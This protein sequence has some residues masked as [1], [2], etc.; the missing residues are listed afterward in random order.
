M[1]VTLQK[2]L[3]GARLKMVCIP[4]L[5]ML[6][7]PGTVHSTESNLRNNNYKIRPIPK[8]INVTGTVKDNKGEPLPGVVVKI[9]GTSTATSTDVN[10]VFRLNL[11]IGTETLVVS[12]LGFET[13]E[14]LAS[15]KT[16]IDIVLVGSTSTLEEVVVVGYG[17]QKKATVTGSIVTINPVEVQ[18]IP[19]ANLSTSL[20]GRLAGVNIGQSSGRP[21]ASTSLS[22]RTRSSYNQEE[23]LYV[24][25]GFIR[26]PGEG[27]AAFDLLDPTEV[28]SISIL[29]DASAA[30]YGARGAGGVVLVKTKSGKEGKAKINYSGSFG[31]NDSRQT[32]DMM[33]AF[34]HAS[35][36]NNALR[37]TNPSNF[38]QQANWFTPDELEAFRSLNYNWLDDVWKNSYTNRHTLNVSGGT[39]TVRYFG[40][41]AFYD[42]VGNLPN[43][44]YNKYTL[45]MG[46]DAD[47]TKDLTASIKLNY[48]NDVD[49]RPFN[50]EDGGNDAMDG[51]FESL[52]QTPRWIPPYLNGLP[53][54]YGGSYQHAIEI[55]N[56]G[57]YNNA[58]AS[59]N[60]MNASLE[61]RV[62]MVKGLTLR[63]GYNQSRGNG[64]GKSYRLPY[65]MYDFIMSGGNN[66]LFTDVQ[67]QTAPALVNNDNRIS[68]SGDKNKSYQ[69]NLSANYSKTF[70]KHSLSALLVYEQA[71]AESSSF[72]ITREG[73]LIKDLEQL[74]AF[75][76][77]RTSGN[78][79]GGVNGRL[80]YAGRINYDYAG[81]Y[82]LEGSFRY[83]GSTK[84]P[85]D[86]RWGFFPALSA[87]WRISEE[88][89][90]K[91]NVTFI[92]N[93]KLR[94]SAGLVGNDSF[95]GS[96]GQWLRTYS[97]TTG[98]Y[99]G[100]SGLTVAIQNRNQGIAS[101][102]VTWEKVATYNGGIDVNFVNNISFTADGFYRDSWDILS[103]PTSAL[104][105]T[106]G[107]GSSIPAIN[108]GTM[109]SWGFDGSVNYD[110]KIKED[111][112]YN[113]GV[114]FSWARSKVLKKFQNAANVGTWKD[115]I[116]KMP[117]W[118]TGYI[119]KGIIRTQEELDALLAQY[120]NYTIFGQAPQLGML[121]Y[122]DMG[123]PGNSDEKDGIITRDDERIIAPAVAALGFGINLGASYK[124][125]RVNTNIGLT[126]FGT[127]VFFDEEAMRAPTAA[128]NGPAFW[129]DHWTPENP[130]AAYPRPANNGQ[131]G[132]K[133]STFY[134]RD[135][136]TMNVNNLSA[137]YDLPASIAKRW[138]VPQFRVFFAGTNLWRIINPLDY[139][140]VSLARFNSYPMI[141]SYNFGLN[142]TI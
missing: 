128:L 76:A 8:W 130:D 110:G 25:D 80:S 97:G 81:K 99:L 10:G 4:L 65:N 15:N 19:A 77:A 37:I 132:G 12:F 123:S 141:R 61:Y 109:R 7:L 41:G 98:A 40:S 52:I 127:K 137:S 54:R 66:H 50:R 26:E 120:P 2:P 36:V 87:G 6:S 116:G 78:S 71:E 32:V 18:D 5:M 58:E 64:D 21:G 53:V 29:K 139:K 117:G 103:V 72:S 23:P 51:T 124:G 59:S 93:F 11:P 62:P 118:T 13:Q 30:I 31:L 82:L 134:M 79:G 101:T 90:F 55:L 28:E 38:E 3:K 142:I 60:V 27:K 89:F 131:D 1:K 49:R 112:G 108:Y 74:A 67:A 88:S 22:I 96:S 16:N 126:G 73:V 136:L 35:L 63:G 44:K 115:E 129:R 94:A 107:F 39:Q 33:S 75:D 114:N 14:V 45:R 86:T 47:I 42:E 70:G 135:G 68:F 20:Q 91:E 102:G 133:V 48:N 119:T 140:D 122:E 105:Q 92:N 104:P 56:E 57:G 100:G 43:T 34:D 46:L 106:S 138:G 85:S 17:E 24:I 125:F 95:I 121:Y 111:F 84:F 69:L 9:K 113:I 83:E